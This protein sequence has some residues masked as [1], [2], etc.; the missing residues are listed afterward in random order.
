VAAG[1]CD[2]TLTN[3]YYLGGMIHSSEPADQEAAAQV[4][5]F[6][7]DAKPPAFT[8]T[9]AARASLAHARHRDHAIKLLEFLASDAAQRW[10]AETNHEYPVNPAI[11]PS[12]T[13]KAWG[14]FKADTLNVRPTG[15][16]EPC[17]CQVDG[18]GRVEIAR[19]PHSDP[20]PPVGRAV[21]AKQWSIGVLAMRC[22]RWTVLVVGLAALLALPVL[23]VFVTALQPAG[24]VWRHL[25]DTVLA[26]YVLNS[27]ALMIGSGREPC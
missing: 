23:T 1:E 22:D 8:S 2:L 7:P 20:L 15:R 6:W 9:S 21:G 16:T 25:A 10:Y 27:V 26:D 14:E 3:T 5:V 11:P 17:R 18:P 4:A 13:L 24:A 12:A 19:P